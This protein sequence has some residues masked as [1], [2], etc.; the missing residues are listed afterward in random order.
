M[1]SLDLACDRRVA[2][3]RCVLRGVVTVLVV[4]AG[5]AAV[6]AGPAAAASPGLIAFASDRAKEFGGTDIYSMTSSGTGIKQLTSHSTLGSSDTAPDWSPDGSKIAFI[7]NSSVWV[8]NA[9]GSSPTQVSTDQGGHFRVSWSPDGT[10][11]AYDYRAFGASTQIVVM[12]ADGLNRHTL[13]TTAYDS[14]NPAWSPDGTRIAFDS[15]RQPPNFVSQ[16]YVMNADGSNQ[17]ALTSDQ[18]PSTDP[19][20]SPDGSKIAFTGTAIVVPPNGTGT[21]ISVMNANGTNEHQLPF[22]PA[23]TSTVA[24]PSWSPDGKMIAFS[25]VVS[26]PNTFEP[27]QVYASNADGTGQVDLSND[28]NAQEGAPGWQKNSTPKLTVQVNDPAGKPV[29][30]VPITVTGPQ[31][32][33][34]V[35]ATDGSA[36]FQL[37]PGNYT[38]APPG[39]G[40]FVAA[41]TGNADC[42]PGGSPL[43]ISCAVNLNQDRTVTFVQ[44]C[45]VP[46]PDGKPLPADTPNPIPGAKTFGQ[47]EAVGCFTQ[48][49]DGTFTATKPVRLNGVDV[50]ATDQ[51]QVVLHPDQQTVTSTGPVEVRIAGQSFGNHVLSLNYEGLTFDPHDLGLFRKTPLAGATLFG[52]PLALGAE[53][54]NAPGRSSLVL[55]VSLPEDGVSK[56]DPVNANFFDPIDRTTAPR[57]P[58]SVRLDMTNRFGFGFGPV[59]G[60]V[61]DLLPFEEGGPRIRSIKLCWTPTPG[62]AF[63]DDGT[64]GL[65][66]SFEVPPKAGLNGYPRIGASADF[67]DYRLLRLAI[68]YDGINKPIGDTGFF[69]QRV[70]GEAKFNP[71]GPA[72]R[73]TEL[74]LGAGVS[75]GP[76]LTIPR[77]ITGSNIGPFELLSGDVDGSIV[78]KPPVEWRV[79]GTLTLLRGSVLEAPFANARVS[80]FNSGLITIEG[81]ALL[82]IPGLGQIPIIGGSTPRFVGDLT[83]FMQ[84]V[85]SYDLEGHGEFAIASHT[86]GASGVLNDHGIIVCT[87][88]WRAGAAFV[89]GSGPQ[90]FS[91]GTCDI[92]PWRRPTPKPARDVA[93]A[94]TAT[95]ATTVTIPGGLPV[96]YI[97]V[98]GRGATP[99]VTLS[100]PAGT[101][102]S[103]PEPGVAAVQGSVLAV[104]DERAHATYFALRR[105]RAGTYR[106]AALP[107]ASPISAS[108]VSVARL[109]PASTVSATTSRTGCSVVVHYRAQP[110]AGDSIELL[111]WSADRLVDLG[112]ARGR[113]RKTFEPSSTAAGSGRLVAIV[114]R[115]GLI[116][117]TRTLA[118]YILNN[119]GT[120]AAPRR[121]KLTGTTAHR[122]LSWSAPCGVSRFRVLLSSGRTV[123]A[124]TVRG[125]HITLGR[126]ARHTVIEVAAL[127]SDGTPGRGARL[128]VR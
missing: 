120:P 83:G 124:R 82:K 116:H 62:K 63:F 47:L 67:K 90:W 16:I 81:H 86:V 44:Q 102:A 50:V 114:R 12:N 65:S 52:A 95:T 58:F 107:G 87:D 88:G 123:T 106:I 60:G 45:V 34:A 53:L 126:L 79:A 66:G 75:L 68:E 39:D 41:S 2:R 42:T 17:T 24:G 21:H 118:R 100:G 13:T 80:L 69:I 112:R 37:P 23:A 22:T 5:L 27:S 125:T 46:T 71:D 105:P 117:N 36:T 20:W 115:D 3:A 85:S 74:T 31:G 28:L 109:A 40:T 9:D 18:Y 127:G 110:A 30:G 99:H 113:G 72:F 11:L 93:T 43:G 38:V 54:Q 55:S 70:R 33:A 48:Q 49:S 103:T 15:N 121:L 92:G 101:L 122:R 59:C 29:T 57:V 91:Q 94:T 111:A 1:R 108:T 76:K 8:M 26:Q 89:W 64:L 96:A 61:A 19:A 35:T 78:L 7:R 10:K 98:L 6:L 97:R 73:P 14:E 119:T 77:I 25:A 84:S 104:R 56:Y 128:R 32:A 4:C 51:S